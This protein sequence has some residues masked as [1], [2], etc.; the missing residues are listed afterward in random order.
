MNYVKKKYLC[1]S[2][3]Y[4]LAYKINHIRNYKQLYLTVPQKIFIP[5]IQLTKSK[6]SKKNGLYAD[7]P[8]FLSAQIPRKSEVFLFNLIINLL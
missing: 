7:F 5:K 1:F 2:F 8:V 3:V 4:N 6:N